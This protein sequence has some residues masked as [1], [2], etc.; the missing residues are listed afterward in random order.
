MMLAYSSASLAAREQM[1]EFGGPAYGHLL[2]DDD[3]ARRS[4]CGDELPE[5][6]GHGFAVMR[7]EDAPFTSHQSEHVRIVNVVQA[8]SRRGLKIYDWV[9]T[10]GGDNDALVEVVVGLK[11]QLHGRS[12][13]AFWMMASR[14][15]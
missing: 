4:L 8:E 6:A 5:M 7:D 3:D 11:A 10:F 1:Q 2:R 13:G 9:E 12:A 14:R 15:R